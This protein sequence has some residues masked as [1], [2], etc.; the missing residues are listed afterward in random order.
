[1]TTALEQLAFFR[2]STVTCRPLVG[3]SSCLAGEKV[4]YDGSDKQLNMLAE[5]RERMELFPLCPEAD[6]GLGIPRPPVQLVLTEQGVQALGRD[7]PELDVTDALLRHRSRAYR[8]M[9]A[10]PLCGYIFKA[11]SPSCGLA[12]APVFSNEETLYYDNG[13]FTDGLLRMF[14]WLV[15]CD[16]SSLENINGLDHFLRQCQLVHEI[17]YDTGMDYLLDI[18]RH[19][20]EQLH[21]L[22]PYSAELLQ[23]YALRENRQKYVELLLDYWREDTEG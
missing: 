13:L 1:M 10:K 17:L 5:M 4:R 14:P 19:Y 23:G 7:D 20:L 9:M 2:D 3:I 6:A 11:R 8:Q 15:T 16:E 21:D 12:S 18:H 22:D